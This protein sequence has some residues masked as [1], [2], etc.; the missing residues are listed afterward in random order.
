MGVH[1]AARPIVKQLFNKTYCQPILAKPQHRQE[2]NKSRMDEEKKSLKSFRLEHIQRQL[3]PQQRAREI[4]MHILILLNPIVLKKNTHL[5][6]LS[7]DFG[8]NST[9]A[10]RSLAIYRC[11]GDVVLIRYNRAFSN[12]S[13]FFFCLAFFAFENMYYTHIAD[14][15]GNG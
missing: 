2:Q 14:T 3:V 5:V 4:T 6:L 12:I 11:D 15:R 9:N 8:C 13:R 1:G 7:F 10:V